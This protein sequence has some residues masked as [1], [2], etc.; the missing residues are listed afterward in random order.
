[1]RLNLCSRHRKK[2][3]LLIIIGGVFVWEAV[4]VIIQVSYFKLTKLSSGEGKRF[5]KMAP[6]H[7]HYELSNWPETKIVVRFWIIGLLLALLSLTT[8]KIR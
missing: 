1:M 3:L 6:I 5:F 8:F 7:H 4:T 2:E